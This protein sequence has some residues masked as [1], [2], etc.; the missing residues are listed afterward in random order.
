MVNFVRVLIILDLNEHSKY[1]DGCPQKDISVIL[2]NIKV[3]RSI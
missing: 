3:K 2:Y 1:G